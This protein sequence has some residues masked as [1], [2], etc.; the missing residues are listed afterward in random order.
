LTP[1]ENLRFLIGLQQPILEDE[2]WQALEKVGLA[3]YEHVL[4]RNLSAGQKRRVALARLYLS[5]AKLWVLDEIFTAIDKKGVAQLEAL[6]EDKAQSG[7]AIVL[8]T[9]HELTMP[10]VKV[11]SLGQVRT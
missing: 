8:T 11:V 6:L 2:L 10:S 7:V 1:L 3:G 5:T 4:C 9:H